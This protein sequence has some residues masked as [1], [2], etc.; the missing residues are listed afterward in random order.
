MSL[1]PSGP[2]LPAGPCTAIYRQRETVDSL[3]KKCVSGFQVLGWQHDPVQRY[4]DRERQRT[5]SIRNVSPSFRSL[6]AS[7]T[8]HSDIDRERQR[9][10]SPLELC[11]PLAIGS[12]IAHPIVRQS[13]SRNNVKQFTQTKGRKLLHTAIKVKRLHYSITSNIFRVQ[14]FKTF[15]NG[16]GSTYKF[17]VN[18]LLK[19]ALFWT[20]KANARETAQKTYKT[21][22]CRRVNGYADRIRSVNY[23]TVWARTP[24]RISLW[25]FGAQINWRVI[26]KKV[27]FTSFLSF[28]KVIAS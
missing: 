2:W 28:F 6:V 7:R 13:P 19:I 5:V 27:L 26:N 24:S 11:L 20:L 3:H 17:C 12:L 9:G 4:T 18:V 10:L 22:F 1:R 14:F 21:F 8:L 16:F 25:W 23:E 15:L